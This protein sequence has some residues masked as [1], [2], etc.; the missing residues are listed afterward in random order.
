MAATVMR[1]FRGDRDLV[2]SSR[3]MV[4]LFEEPFNPK[5]MA[6]AA[7]H[8]MIMPNNSSKQISEEDFGK[9]VLVLTMSEKQKNKLY[10]Q[11]KQAINVY[12]LSEYAR[13]DKEE[14]K[15]PYGGTME[16]YSKCFEE[17]YDLVAKVAEILFKDMEDEKD[18]ESSIRM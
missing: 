13:V 17:I 8:N 1:S 14:I 18:N 10:A 7:A 3:G 5:A 4:V 9:D 6:V 11:Y 2:V 15:D 16:D 12:T